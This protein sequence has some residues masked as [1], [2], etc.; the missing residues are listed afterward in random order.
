MRE[1]VIFRRNL[2]KVSEPFIAQQAQQLRRYTPLYLGRLRHGDQ[3]A[4]AEA[5]SFEDLAGRWSRPLAAW[6]MF[7]RDTRA[8]ERLLRG[9]RP[10]LIHAHFG[11]DGVY[12]LP[13]AR[14]LGI[15]LITT[16]HGF[17]ALLR[18]PALMGSPDWAQYRLFRSGLARDGALFICVS[19]FIRDR[20]L[21]MGFPAARTRI[22]YIGVDCDTIRARDPAEETPTVLHVARLVEFK[23]T[24]YLIRAFAAQARMRTETRLVII[25]DGPLKRRLRAL[26]RS[27]GLGE[28]VSFLGARPHAEVRAWMRKAAL[29]VLPSVRTITGR[30]EALGQVLLEAAASGVPV[31]GSREGGIPESV[32]D[33]RT[34]FLVPARDP[35]AL[36]RRMIELLDDSTLRYRMGAA[37]RAHVERNFDI[38]R[39]TETLE[40]LYDVVLSS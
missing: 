9:R 40:N 26:A 19:A 34:G 7:T 37:A 22:H 2:F 3:P 14:R 16:F 35:D 33:G 15:P 32:I 27:L 28:R 24:Q 1:V 13:L 31:I 5:F 23:G 10:S 30:V 4:G 8:F 38:R 6:Q 36:A 20:V 17:D 21:A 29:L 18:T 12:A 39:Q 11:V 25:G